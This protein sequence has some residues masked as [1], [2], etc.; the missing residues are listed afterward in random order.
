MKKGVTTSQAELPGE[1]RVPA[2]EIEGRILRIQ[3]ELRKAEIDGL[4]VIQ[5]VDLFYFSGTAQNG[6]L[7][8]PAEGAPLLLIKKHYSEWV[9]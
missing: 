2:S 8:I 3:E 1:F 4:L 9:Y 7:F 6:F 5:R